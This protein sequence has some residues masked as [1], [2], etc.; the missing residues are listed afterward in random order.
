MNLYKLRLIVETACIVGLLAF[1]AYASWHY[2]AVGLV[3]RYAIIVSGIALLALLPIAVIFGAILA[4]RGRREKRRM[5][6][7]WLARGAE[8][9]QLEL[10]AAEQTAS[11]HIAD[12]RHLP[13]RMPKQP[14][15]APWYMRLLAWRPP[16]MERVAAG[17]PTLELPPPR[18]LTAE[19]PAAGDM[20]PEPLAVLGA[21]KV[22]ALPAWVPRRLTPGKSAGKRLVLLTI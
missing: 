3:M 13:P 20:T 5:R 19:L 10:A 12:G 4:W 7:E 22:P 11:R 8:R 14:E 1:L 21:A 18:A 2:R 6:K 15:R 16:F 9:A 17:D